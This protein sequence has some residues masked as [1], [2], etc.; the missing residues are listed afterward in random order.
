[1][2][3]ISSSYSFPPGLSGVLPI[4]VPPHMPYSSTAGGAAATAGA[5]AAMAAP[6][7]M[8]VPLHYSFPG[9]SPASL[10]AAAYLAS[11]PRVRRIGAGENG[12]HEFV[13]S[14]IPSGLSLSKR[15]AFSP[16]SSSRRRRR[17]VTNFTIEG[18][19]G[20]NKKE[21]VDEDADEDDDHEQ[22]DLKVLVVDT[23]S[24]SEPMSPASPSCLKDDRHLTSPPHH[25]FS[26]DQHHQVHETSEN[27]LEDHREDDG[28]NPMTRFS[29]LQCTRYKPPRLPSK[30]PISV[31]V[32]N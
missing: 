29:W 11:S 2:A 22:Q 30:Y 16:P 10:S 31:K 28:N 8:R 4:N 32:L 3:L 17:R 24:S 1:M 27:G 14:A 6:A 7:W 9:F 23:N 12:N 18:I 26:S 20:H 13:M 15:L 19:L 21:E 5:A 25:L